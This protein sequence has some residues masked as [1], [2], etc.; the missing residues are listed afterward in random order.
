MTGRHAVL[1]TTLVLAA[2]ADGQTTF[3]ARNDLQV[4]AL[5]DGRFEV[6]A[7][8]G[9]GPREYFCAAGDFAQRRLGAPGG[10]RVVLA[11]VDGPSRSR[12]RGRSTVFAVVAP[13]NAP[14]VPRGVGLSVR[15]TG[16]N[17]SVT[18]A[19]GLCERGSSLSISF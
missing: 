12:D 13:Q 11:E 4:A 15:R 18:Q 1:A 9:T 14:T 16:E 5:P 2:C 6:F 17:V 19:R 8:P 3:Q 10:A 7:R